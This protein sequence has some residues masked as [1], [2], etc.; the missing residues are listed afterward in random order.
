MIHMVREIIGG[1]Q[2]V[3]RRSKAEMEE[4]AKLR[5]FDVLTNWPTFQPTERHG[6]CLGLILTTLHYLY[7]LLLPPVYSILC[8]VIINHISSAK[9]E[10]R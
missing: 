10:S 4:E 1:M 6:T 7:S 8:N 5:K 3:G 2:V 9:G